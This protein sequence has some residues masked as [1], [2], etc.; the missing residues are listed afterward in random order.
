MKNQINNLIGLLF[1]L[2]N[3]K[4]K[5]ML[6]VLVLLI[7]EQAGL[8]GTFFYDSYSMIINGC[9]L[10]VLVGVSY[11]YW[12]VTLP[13]LY[14]TMSYFAGKWY[15]Y[16]RNSSWIPCD[17]SGTIKFYYLTLALVGLVINAIAILDSLD[18][19]HFLQELLNYF[20][21]NISRDYSIL[22]AIF[23]PATAPLCEKLFNQ[24]FSGCS[25]RARYY[26]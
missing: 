19:L 1:S 9:V 14:C 17:V 11:F 25:P 7:R 26:I 20:N 21:A 22:L 2:S 15:S 23:F 16:T 10:L 8:F 3:L 5:D 6:T 4:M 18:V 12:L 13:S 24:Q